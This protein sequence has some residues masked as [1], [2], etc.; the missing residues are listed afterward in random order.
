MNIGRLTNQKDQITILKA[1]NILKKKINFEMII[2]GRGILKEELLNFIKLNN[3]TKNVKIMDFVENPF[4][5]IKQSDLFILSSKYEG[6]P[7]VLLEALVLKKFI[8]S[9]NCRTGPKEILINGKGGLL[10]KV[11]NYGQLAKQII[12]F[13]NNKATCKNLL[14]KSTKALY[15]FDYK[16]NLKK[17]FQLVQS[18]DIKAQ[19]Y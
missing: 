3:L 7:N 4:P 14:K 5:L 13:N 9:T 12:Y 10:F 6:L 2:I 8:I 1:L 17:Y 11:G 18:I 15:R 16:I 19:E